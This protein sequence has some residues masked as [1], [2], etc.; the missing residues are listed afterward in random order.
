MWELDHKEGWALKYWCFRTAVLEKT[1]K[2]SLDSKEIK[3]VNSKGNQPWIYIGRTDAET[4]VPILW[5]PDA[6]KWLIGKDPDTG[7]D[8]GQE[9]KG[10][11]EDEMVGG[12]H[13]LNG[14]EFEQTLGNS[15]GQGN[16]VCWSPWGHKELD[17]TEWLNSHSNPH[18]IALARRE[19]L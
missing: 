6:K 2:S 17:M 14:R 1:L 3:A 8:G 7:K 15:E 12:L 4:E 5:A 10:V 11:T 19:D 16:L 18:L 9:E 13:Q